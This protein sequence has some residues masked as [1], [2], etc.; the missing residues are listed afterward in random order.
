MKTNQYIRNLL[1]VACLGVAACSP[2][3]DT[4]GYTNDD[5]WKQEVLVGKSTKDQV[6]ANL[7]SPS[8][9]SSFGE[10]TWYY[11]SDRKEAVAFLKPEV[12]KQ[13]I[14]KI[15][16]NSAG[17]VTSAGSYDENG[18][19]SFGL[20]NRTTPTEGHSFGFFEQLLGNVGRFNHPTDSVAPGRQ[21]GNGY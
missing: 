15:T 21:G 5:N 9:R 16:F 3:V 10:E 13:D 4:R 14:F 6:M 20:V 11:I 2:K 19:Q 7:G 17:I 1:L 18:A 8:T 12:V